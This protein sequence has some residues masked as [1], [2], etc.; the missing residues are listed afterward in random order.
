MLRKFI[1]IPLLLSSS[2]ALAQDCSTQ[3]YGIPDL[4]CDGEIQIVVMGDSLVFGFGDTKNKNKG[5]YI[6]RARKAMPNVLIQNLG[7]QGLNT[8]GLLSIIKAAFDDDTSLKVKAALI[9]A[10]VIVLDLG[11]N[12]RWLFGEPVTAVKNLVDA[13][14]SIQAEVKKITKIAPLVVNAVIMLPN[15]GAQGPWVKD[16]NALVQKTNTALRPADLRFDLVSKRLLGKDQIHPTSKGYDALASTFVKYLKKKLPT[17]LNNWI[18][19][20]RPDPVTVPTPTPVS[21]PV[22]SPTPGE[23]VG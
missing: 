6:T 22:P 9:S 16:F 8:E 13:G 10:D 3:A 4:N 18:L 1:L 7:F 17:R 11:R 2:V 20:T 5:G 19:K 15:R 23:I 14:K 21:D 12:D